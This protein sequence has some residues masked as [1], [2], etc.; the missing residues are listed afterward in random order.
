MKNILF[1]AIDFQ[2]MYVDYNF[3]DTI[4]I[5]NAFT[6]FESMRKHSSTSGAL[7]KTHIIRAV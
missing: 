3:I 6:I 2:D 4:N 1:A 7:D 5:L